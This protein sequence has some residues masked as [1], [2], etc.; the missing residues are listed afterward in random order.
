MT[1]TIK[2][3]DFAPKSLEKSFWGSHTYEDLGM[4]LE[5]ANEWIRRNYNVEIINVETVVMPNI[6]IKEASI[7]DQVTQ[8]AT[9]GSIVQNFQ[10]IR[11]WYKG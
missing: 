6:F 1:I 8:V 7:T 9:G 2:H 5:R 4:V 11:I 3:I 10:I